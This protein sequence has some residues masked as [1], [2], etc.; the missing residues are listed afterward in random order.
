MI[1]K[2]FRFGMLLQLA[3]GP[4]CLF[5]FS[6]AAGSGFAVAFSLVCAVT[7]TDAVYIALS[8]V[9]ACS[10]LKKP[11]IQRAVKIVGAAILVLFGVDTIAGAFG[12]SV[13][14]SIH[15]FAQATGKTVFVQGLLLTATNPLTILFWGGVFAAQVM[16]N[17]YNSRQMAGFGVGCVLATLSFLCAVA[18]LGTVANRF[19]SAGILAALN[20]GVGAML[21]FFGIRLLVRRQ[22][23]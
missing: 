6:T 17:G 1:F 14:P 9:G 8:A 3:V 18:Y 4:V 12:V 13:L 10:V 5:V 2:G 21:V 19:L 15:L 23:E 11:G 7:L 22:P 20:V 16:E